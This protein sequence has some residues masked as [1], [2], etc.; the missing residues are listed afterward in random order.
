MDAMRGAV[1]FLTRIPVGRDE[2]AWTA[3]RHT[4]AVGPVAGYLVGGLLVIPFLIGLPAAT[5]AVLFVAWVYLLTGINHLDGVADLGDAAVVHGD[6]EDRRMVMKDTQVGVGAVLGVGIVLLGLAAAGFT[7]ATLP[8]AAVG[9]VIA[10]EVGAK[11]GMATVACLGHS[12]HEGLGASVI[13]P[14]DR[15]DLVPAVALSVPA[16]ALTGV[17]VAAGLA[18]LGGFIVALGMLAWSDRHLGGQ[19]G[20]VLGATNELSRLVGLHLGAIAWTL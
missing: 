14:A 11:L 16:V 8:V 15:R 9:I 7:L 19:S 2:R 5:T 1:G 6:A 17:H 18:V 13:D 4:P 3:F 20:D 12:A 10:A